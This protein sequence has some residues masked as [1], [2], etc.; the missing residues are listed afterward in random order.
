MPYMAMQVLLESCILRLKHKPGNDCTILIFDLW[1]LISNCLATSYR[2]IV[3]PMIIWMGIFFT[4][5]HKV[6]M[7]VML[8]YTCITCIYVYTQTHTKMHVNTHTHAHTHPHTRTHTNTGGTISLSYIS[9]NMFECLY[10]YIYTSRHHS[11][12]QFSTNQ[13]T[14]VN[15]T[16][17]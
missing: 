4:R 9:S 6:K 8:K 14:Y 11:Y 15:P 7:D 5:A 3:F 16:R 1:P 13:A 12:C 17:V 2:L 10:I